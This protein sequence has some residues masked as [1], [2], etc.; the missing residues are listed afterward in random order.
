M[1]NTILGKRQTPLPKR[2]PIRLLCAEISLHG[3]LY[4]SDV[5]DGASAVLLVM[6]F[7]SKSGP[8]RLS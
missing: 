1:G 8:L 3:S 4:K 5:P 7:P 2:L 6:D